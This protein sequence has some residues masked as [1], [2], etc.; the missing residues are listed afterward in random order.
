MVQLVITNHNI[1]NK[2]NVPTFISSNRMEITDLTLGTDKIQDL[3]PNW[4][5]SDEISSQHRYTLLTWVTHTLPASH[6]TAP[7][8]TKVQ[9][10]ELAANMV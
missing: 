6:I 10:V 2:G 1:I 8:R 9:E 4:Q 7:L 3:V 5:V